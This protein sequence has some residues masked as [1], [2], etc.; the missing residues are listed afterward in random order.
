MIVLFT[1]QSVNVHN[2]VPYHVEL[3]L[4]TTSGA[5]FIDHTKDIIDFNAGEVRIISED[6]PAGGKPYKNWRRV[7]FNR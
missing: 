5:P 7:K 6:L 3:R 4:I 1:D 2:I